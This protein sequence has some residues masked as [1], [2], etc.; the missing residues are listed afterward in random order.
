MSTIDIR[1]MHAPEKELFIEDLGKISGGGAMLTTQ[2]QGEE[3]PSILPG[4]C[5]IT[6]PVDGVEE[7]LRDTLS[8]YPDILSKL[9]GYPSWPFS[10]PAPKIPVLDPGIGNG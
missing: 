7:M 9:P 1:D 6:D 8:K 10:G 2:A 4:G 3:G 5:V